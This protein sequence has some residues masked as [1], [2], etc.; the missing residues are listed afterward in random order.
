[1]KPKRFEKNHEIETLINSDRKLPP[2]IVANVIKPLGGLETV[3]RLE[4]DL[5]R[6]LSSHLRV[7]LREN[8]K[9]KSRQ[10]LTAG[11]KTVLS[12]YLI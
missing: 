3:D 12:P 10:Q 8:R 5:L 4:R 1:M 6:R 9:L 7:G 2:A 11:V